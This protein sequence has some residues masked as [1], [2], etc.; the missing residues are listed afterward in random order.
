M[1]A[2][3]DS[4]S[5]LSKTEAKSFSYYAE[6]YFRKVFSFNPPLNKCI[7]DN[8]EFCCLSLN[9]CGSK[10]EC[11]NSNKTMTVLK[12][13]FISISI[14]LISFLIYKIYI[15]DPEPE[16]G[17]EDKIDDKTLNM[18]IEIFKQNRDNRRKFNP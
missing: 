10:Q 4:R 6:L 13:I 18:L 12:S 3:Y 15:T 7:E 5:E 11:E 2:E 14:I 9:F 1:F 8:C 16:H 17:E